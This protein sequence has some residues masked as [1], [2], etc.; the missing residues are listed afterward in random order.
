MDMWK[1][2]YVDELWFEMTLFN[3]IY[4]LSMTL[5]LRKFIFIFIQLLV[6][7]EISIKKESLLGWKITNIIGGSIYKL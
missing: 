3:R 4:R 6:Q 7:V 5:S 2:V 1:S